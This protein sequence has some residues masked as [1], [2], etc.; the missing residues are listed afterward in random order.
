ML[1]ISELIGSTHNKLGKGMINLKLEP[2]AES[3]DSHDVEMKALL[4][5]AKRYIIYILQIQNGEDLLDLLLSEITPTD[6]FKFREL[7]KAER[8]RLAS[9][10]V[11]SAFEKEALN[12]IFNST[13][14]QV[15]KRAIE[16]ILGLERMGALTR[17]DGYQ[18]LL[19][20]IA[21]DIKTVKSQKEERDRQFRVVIDTLTKL[22]QK[23]R[24]C[25]KIYN[26]YIND[27]DNAMF[28]LQSKSSHKKKPLLS[29]LFSRQYYYQRE[30]KKKK[31][32]L[33]KFGYC[34]YSS[35]YMMDHKILVDF[36]NIGS[37]A[38]TFK[39]SKIQLT[40]SCFKIG[41]FVVGVANGDKDVTEKVTLD[42][43]LNLQ[44]EQKKTFD[45]FNGCVIFDTDNFVAFIFKKFYE[46]GAHESHR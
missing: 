33:P 15:K 3:T 44:Y 35:K 13:F 36:K 37:A 6:E 4:L 1:E 7:A 41:E 39:S 26:S 17:N 12:E 2:V 31:G 45:I 25:A 10:N 22:K 43:L 29:R 34:R 21:F 24:T 14:P 38:S 18:E 28:K 11:E 8:K 16:L 46:A 23:E 27:I 32:Y 9:S 19:N 20:D 30:L 42:N 40:F 5:E